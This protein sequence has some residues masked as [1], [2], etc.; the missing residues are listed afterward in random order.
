MRRFSTKGKSILAT[1]LLTLA[2]A[3]MAALV[4]LLFYPKFK[5][6][7]RRGPGNPSSVSAT[8][9]QTPEIVAAA[10]SQVFRDGVNLFHGTGTNGHIPGTWYRFR[11]ARFGDPIFPDDF[12]LTAVSKQDAELRR[13]AALPAGSRRQD[14]YLLEPTGDYYWASEYYYRGEPARFRC[15]FII[16]LEP[17]E[18]ARSKIEIFE[19]V[20]SIWVGEK[21]GWSAHTGPIPGFFYDIRF[22]AP[23][24]ADRAEVLTKI[25]EAIAQ[26]PT[27]TARSETK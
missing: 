11:V 20:P 16:H 24:T 14:F 9:R 13:Y 5:R 3:A 15:N 18:A 26:T 1:T 23:T 25:L 22:S 8:V 12:Q 6:I 10:I 27:A 2:V 19:Y 7:E 21:F 17:Q 4:A